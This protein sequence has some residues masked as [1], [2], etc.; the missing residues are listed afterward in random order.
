MT[1][2][3]KLFHFNSLLFSWLHSKTHPAQLARLMLLTHDIAIIVSSIRLVIML[4]KVSE[5][6]PQ[7]G[8]AHKI[9]SDLFTRHRRNVA[10]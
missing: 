2:R 9:T 1:L 10:D 3:E 4:A 7:A 6:T 8:A 5:R